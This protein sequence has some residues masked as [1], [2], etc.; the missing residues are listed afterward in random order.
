MIEFHDVTEPSFWILQISVALPPG[1]SALDFPALATLEDRVRG[2]VSDTDRVSVDTLT[3]K[4]GAIRSYL[5][6]VLDFHVR[7]PDGTCF[8]GWQPDGRS[9]PEHVAEIFEESTRAHAVS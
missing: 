2:M 3:A 9:H 4:P 6:S 1:A 8:C 7:Q 5:V